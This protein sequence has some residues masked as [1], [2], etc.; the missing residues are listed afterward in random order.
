[1]VDPLV[2]GTSAPGPARADHM[3][4]QAPSSRPVSGP[5]LFARFAFGPNRLGYCG[6]DA[7]A[8]LLG[9]ATGS[10]DDRA[11][12]QLARGFD[13]AWPYLELIAASNGLTDPLDRRVVEAY[14]LGN[15]LLRRVPPGRFAASLDARFRPR[16]RTGE[17][18]WLA[19]SIGFGAVPVHAFHVFD[20]F[21]R[22]GLLRTG[23]VDRALEVMDSCRVR[24]GRVLDRV[25]DRLV[26]EVAPLELRDGRLALGAPRPESV[27][28]WRDGVGFVDDV[29]RGE[30]IAIHWSWACDRLSARQLTGLSSWT[31][32]Q[33]DVANLAI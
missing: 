9:E 11:L 18:R 28:A 23:A 3:M 26:V 19:G 4:R 12:H 30:M 14:W 17:W 5:V 27:E 21:P 25:G 33:L 29:A 10:R 6:P 8:E 13:G 20:V 2:L 15:D 32:R 16:I 31:E 22:V 1:M 24:W 7:A